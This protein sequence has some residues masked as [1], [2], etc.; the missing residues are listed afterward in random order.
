MSSQKEMVPSNTVSFPTIAETTAGSE[1]SLLSTVATRS[2]RC[3]AQ[4]RHTFSLCCAVSSGQSSLW[5]RAN[6]CSRPIRHRYFPKHPCLQNICNSRKV[7]APCLHDRPYHRN[8]GVPPHWVPQVVLPS[9][10]PGIVRA[11][12]I[13]AQEHEVTA[14]NSAPVPPRATGTVTR[15]LLPPDPRTMIQPSDRPPHRRSCGMP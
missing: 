3:D 8:Y 10:P 11:R 6:A 14:L 9:P 5:W 1:T 12:T 7:R 4:G 15:E 13:V 2:R